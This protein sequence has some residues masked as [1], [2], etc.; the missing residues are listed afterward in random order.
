[1]PPNRKYDKAQWMLA[2]E[3]LRLTDFRP[4][5]P[6]P[7]LS[8]RPA[9]TEIFK[10]LDDQKSSLIQ[11]VQAQWGRLAGDPVADHSRPA[12]LIDHVLYVCVDSSAWLNEI[13]RFHAAHIARLLQKKFGEEKIRKICYQVN[14][15]QSRRISD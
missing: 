15:R 11:Q 3:R 1:M 10:K 12:Q 9:L 6:E 4:T 13:S 7:D 5:P 14:P 2:R 8:L